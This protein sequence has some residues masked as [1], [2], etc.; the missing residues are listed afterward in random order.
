MEKAALI[1]A[2][3]VSLGLTLNGCMSAGLLSGINTGS[4]SDTVSVK[5]PSRDIL[6]IGIEVA[7][8]MSFRITSRDMAQKTVILEYGDMGSWSN[9]LP[10]LIGKIDNNNIILT[11]IDARSLSIQVSTTGTF[12]SGDYSDAVKILNEFKK[13][14][15]ARMQ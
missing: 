3:V 9:P 10:L 13:R 14:I 6:T 12:G 4:V 8:S 7:Q 15:A 1:L 5:T 11:V 2:L